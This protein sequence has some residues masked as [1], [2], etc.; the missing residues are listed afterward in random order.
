[1]PGKSLMDSVRKAHSLDVISIVHAG[2]E[3]RE[4]LTVL[5]FSAAYVAEPFKGAKECLE[6]GCCLRQSSLIA[7]TQ[8]PEVSR[9]QL[10]KH[11]VG[12][13]KAIPTILLVDR[14][15]DHQRTRTLRG[16]TTLSQSKPLHGARNPL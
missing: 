8:L 11:L 10:Y 3:L 2:P 6:S 13:G 1:M 12:S 16:C 4:E 15:R 5:C 14:L 7:E 9:L